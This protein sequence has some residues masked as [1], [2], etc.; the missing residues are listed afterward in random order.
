M[1]QQLR[2]RFDGNMERYI[3]SV[4]EHH[5]IAEGE[6]ANQAAFRVVETDAVRSG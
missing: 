1:R 4:N 6:D 3:E 5:Q 2:D